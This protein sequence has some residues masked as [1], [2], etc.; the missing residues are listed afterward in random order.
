MREV[1]DRGNPETIVIMP[2]LADEI[3]EANHQIKNYRDDISIG[4]GFRSARA[5]F[6]RN[7][8]DRN[9]LP[10]KTRTDLLGRLQEVPFSASCS[11]FVMNCFSFDHERVTKRR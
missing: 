2:V 1:P 8:I 7:I 10:I 9:S 11:R 4:Q 6:S 5:K 3:E